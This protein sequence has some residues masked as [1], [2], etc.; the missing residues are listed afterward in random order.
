M[1]KRKE[2]G[3][4]ATHDS[5]FIYQFSD[6]I[7]H[8]PIYSFSPSFIYYELY[9]AIVIC[10]VLCPVLCGV[11]NNDVFPLLLPKARFYITQLSF[12]ESPLLSHPP[13][14]KDQMA[15]SI[16]VAGP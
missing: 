3:D 10:P 2:D 1:S 7:I 6:I 14:P 11:Q 12:K 13:H 9:L 5:L 8:P 15:R 16:A 4:L